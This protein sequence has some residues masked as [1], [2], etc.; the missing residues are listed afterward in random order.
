MT[1]FHIE[2]VKPS[3]YDKDGYV[4]QWWKAWIPSNSM[5]CLY[6]ISQECAQSRILGDDVEIEVNAYDE[7]NIRIPIERITAQ[8]RQPGHGGLVCL[9]GVQS[10]QF[11]RAMAIA[12]QFRASGVAVAIGGFHVS[13]CVAMLKELP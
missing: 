1:T 11:P 8:I 9:V 3:H 4:I 12:R 6:A 5:A 2:I 10:N 7:M 13:G